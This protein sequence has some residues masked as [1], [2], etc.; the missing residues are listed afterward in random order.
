MNPVLLILCLTKTTHQQTT[1]LPDE[2]YGYKRVSTTSLAKIKSFS[3]WT[4]FRYTPIN[5]TIVLLLPCNL[6]QYITQKCLKY[7][8][9][10]RSH[11]GKFF[12]LILS[13]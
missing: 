10:F 9:L 12:F 2:W 8:H 5:G 6:K 11:F 13:K 1:N 7:E 3:A 4:G